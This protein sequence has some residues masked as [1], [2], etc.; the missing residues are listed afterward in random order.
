MSTYT[1]AEIAQAMRDVE[2]ARL[3]LREA[4]ERLKDLLQALE[5]PEASGY[6]ADRPAI[7]P[8]RSQTLRSANPD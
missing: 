4:A 5:T 8:A 3:S 2:A 7:D 6:T 1:P